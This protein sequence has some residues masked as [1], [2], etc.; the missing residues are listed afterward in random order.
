MFEWWK[1]RKAAQATR[2]E[3]QRKAIE[4]FNAGLAELF[5]PDLD[6]IAG[7]NKFAELMQLQIGLAD[8]FCPGWKEEHY[9]DLRK[10]WGLRK[11]RSHLGEIFLTEGP[12]F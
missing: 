11:L 7:M 5:K 6:P 3:V 12:L 1:K 4:A 9:C 10:V 8:A 2:K